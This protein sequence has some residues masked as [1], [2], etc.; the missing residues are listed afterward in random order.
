MS[1]NIE[2]FSSTETHLLAF[3]LPDVYSVHRSF[4]DF[5]FVSARNMCLVK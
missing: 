2:V 4:V 5:F 3:A 1:L